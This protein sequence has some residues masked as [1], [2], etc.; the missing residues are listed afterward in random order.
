MPINKISLNKK[1]KVGVCIAVALL[2]LIYLVSAFVNTVIGAKEKYTGDLSVP[3]SSEAD[4]EKRM[5]NMIAANIGA[6]ASEGNTADALPPSVSATRSI[7]LDNSTDRVLYAKN[8]YSKAPMASTTKIM[9]F[10]VAIEHCED[11]YETVTVSRAAAYTDGSSMH[12]AEGETISLHDLF[13]GLLLNSGNDAAV[14]IAEHIG[15]SVEDFCKM[16]DDRAASLGAMNT[17]FKS[18]HGLDAEGH[19]TTAYDLALIAKEAYKQPLFREIIG[20]STTTLNGHYLKNTNPFLGKYKDIAGGKTG[21]TGDAGR[22][23][24]YFIDTKDI[25]VIVVMLGCPTSNDRVSDGVKLLHYITDNF[26][27]YTIVKRGTP[28]DNFAVE[29]G[30]QL[31]VSGIID[32]DVRITLKNSECANVSASYTR[33]AARST[34]EEGYPLVSA[35]VAYSDTLGQLWIKCGSSCTVSI[36]VTAESSVPRKT[37]TDHLG[38]MINTLPYFFG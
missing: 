34:S 33:T 18:P 4:I 31:A 7:V 14:A 36:D 19:Y 28:V 22:C 32:S 8:S 3:L 37:Y 23:M 17:K 27:T 24:V 20:T 10:I 38:D 1:V 16:M 13:Y 29:K 21:Y 15:G 26:K 2:I 6:L 12:L 5:S 30:R 25:Q 35:P 9:T 11:L